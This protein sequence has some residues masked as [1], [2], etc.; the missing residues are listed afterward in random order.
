MLCLSKDHLQKH[1]KV[2]PFVPNAPF[3][4]PLKTSE[5]VKVFWGFQGVEKGCIG[6]K[7]VK[8]S[9]AKCESKDD[10]VSICGKNNEKNHEAEERK[11]EYSHSLQIYSNLQSILLQTALIKVLNTE[12]KQLV[13]CCVISDSSCQRTHCTEDLADPLNLKPICTKLKLEN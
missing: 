8:Y 4:Y 9:G 3:L 12:E 5:N 2:N 13:Y 11:D 7:W 6:N 10:Y 1:C